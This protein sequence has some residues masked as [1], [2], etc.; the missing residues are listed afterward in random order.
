MNLAWQLPQTTSIFARTNKISDCHRLISNIRYRSHLKG[1]QGLGTIQL[2]RDY[3]HS[4]YVQRDWSL[5]QSTRFIKKIYIYSEVVSVHH[6]IKLIIESISW[7]SKAIHCS[8]SRVE[9]AYYKE[10]NPE[11]LRFV[12][13]ESSG[14]RKFRA[15]N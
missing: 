12:A 6:T 8:Q 7:Y 4:L 9:L 2:S 3:V 5:W 13:K 15:L 1:R 11:W 14:N 10:P